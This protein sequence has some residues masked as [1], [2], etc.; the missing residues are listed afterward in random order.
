MEKAT[1]IKITEV[2]SREEHLKSA[3]VK[4]TEIMDELES[5]AADLDCTQTEQD[6]TLQLQRAHESVTEMKE[7]F[8]PPGSSVYQRPKPIS[9]YLVGISM[10]Y[11]DKIHI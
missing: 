2:E 11:L 6:V 1:Q 7:L 9:S 8:T 5:L 4:N 10:T 3:L